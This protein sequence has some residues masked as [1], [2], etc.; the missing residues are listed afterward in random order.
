MKEKHKKDGDSDVLQQFLGQSLHGQPVDGQ[1][2]TP[3]QVSEL[4]AKHRHQSTS[5]GP[6]EAGGGQSSM[7]TD[8]RLGGFIRGTPENPLI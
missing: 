1:Q 2:L 5:S 8:P 6:A 7:A 3:Q 4:V